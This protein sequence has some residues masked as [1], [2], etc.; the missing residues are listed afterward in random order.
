[1]GFSRHEYWNGLPCPPPG[2]LPDPGMEPAFI[3]SPA[4]AGQFFTTRGTWGAPEMQ[5][6]D[7]KERGPTLATTSE[8]LED[9][10]ALAGAPTRP[11]GMSLDKLY[12][13]TTP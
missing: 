12:R 10:W 13:E 3:T 7:A 11:C 6:K 8:Q 5:H 1:M 2:S 4:V 9:M